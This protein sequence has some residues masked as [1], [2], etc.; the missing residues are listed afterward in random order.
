MSLEKL[1]QDI[2]RSPWEYSLHQL[3]AILEQTNSKKAQFGCGKK[4]S[5][6]P[7]ILNAYCNFSAPSSDCIEFKEKNGQTYLTI[8]QTSLI[9]INGILPQRYS[10][11]IITKSREG[12]NCLLDFMN[13]FNQRL[14]GLMHKIEKKIR[15]NLNYDSLHN[16]EY[17]HAL[18]GIIKKDGRKKTHRSILPSFASFMWQKNKSPGGL[19]AILQSIFPKF[20]IEIQQF[21]PHTVEI[22]E[23][24]RAKLDKSKLKDKM[25]GKR[26]MCTQHSIKI[27][28]LVDSKNSYDSILPGTEN[29]SLIKEVA[30]YYCPPGFKIKFEFRLPKSQKPTCALTLEKKLGYNTW[31]GK[32]VEKRHINKLMDDFGCVVK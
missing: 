25:L 31:L 3:L 21:I 19:I 10:E 24:Y 6:E 13:I 4:P 17:C 28:I 30:K 14:F 20:H 8:N 26:A 32:T 5:D 15:L 22:H 23:E 29:F 7:S 9:G 18:A 2:S 16:F 12:N 27:I 11:K 1:K